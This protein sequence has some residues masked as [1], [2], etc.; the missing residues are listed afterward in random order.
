M[1]SGITVLLTSMITLVLGEAAPLFA[2]D[3]RSGKEDN[4]PA[5]TPQLRVTVD[6]RVELVSLLFRLAGN[7][8]YNQCR[9]PSYSADVE[10]QFGRFRNHTAVAFARELRQT[11]SVSYDACMSLAVILT[12]GDYSVFCCQRRT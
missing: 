2:A 4:P 8:E 1:K 7:P 6:A 3:T 11:Q 10:K 5:S 12:G 9:I